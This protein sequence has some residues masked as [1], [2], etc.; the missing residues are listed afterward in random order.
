MSAFQRKYS[1]AQR[2][3]YIGAVLERGMSAAR[4]AQLAAAGELKGTD[5]AFLDPFDVPASTV[6]GD[7]RKARNRRLGRE[8]SDL[9]KLPA[10]DA[11]EALRRRMVSLADRELRD[12][13][14]RPAG[15]VDP[16][17]FRQ[18]GRVL[19][20]L[21]AIPGPKDNARPAPGQ[22]TG[23]E[24][25]GG[26]TRNGLAGE[27]LRAHK[28]GGQAST[29]QD[30]KRTDTHAE[31]GSAAHRGAVDEGAAETTAGERPGSLARRTAAM[32]V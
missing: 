30:A 11:I 7:A 25:H 29:A 16:E 10:R 32:P 18:I 14:R 9:A 8:A 5:G 21:Q 13:E 31:T 19:R 24:Q 20:E 23:G 26:Q 6:R 22:K 28:N 17:R 2:D 15:T 3:A 12:L 1:D 4:V 27:L